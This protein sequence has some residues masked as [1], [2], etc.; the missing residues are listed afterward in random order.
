M[1]HFII[2]K[3]FGT[4]KLYNRWIRY[5][6][7]S[8]FALIIAIPLLAISYLSIQ[9]QSSSISFF[10]SFVFGAS[11]L[12]FITIWFFD[13][14]TV[15]NA[16][17]LC[18]DSALKSVEIV[19][20]DGSKTIISIGDFTSIS[21]EKITHPKGYVW[22]A[23]LVGTDNAVVLETGS[24]KRQLAKW[25]KPVSDWLKIPIVFSDKAIDGISWMFQS[26][27]RIN[28]YPDK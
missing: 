13:R 12:L 15:K 10:I 8:W 19:N 5:R 9:I 7:P 24:T 14:K 6:L 3:N 1:N 20:K 4:L 22:R 28:P 11:G 23:T 2:N 18:I 17:T 16:N 26:N 21:I 27:P 25:I